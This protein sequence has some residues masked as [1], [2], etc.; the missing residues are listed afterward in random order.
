MATIKEQR[1]NAP[2]CARLGRGRYCAHHRSLYRHY[3]APVVGPDKKLLLVH[4]RYLKKTLGQLVSADDETQGLIRK[5]ASIAFEPRPIHFQDNRGRLRR[6]AYEASVWQV[7]RIRQCHPG[8]ANER[9]AERLWWAFLTVQ[10]VEMTEVFVHQDRHH[11]WTSVVRLL[12][13]DTHRNKPSSRYAD[14]LQ[15]RLNTLLS[16]PTAKWCSKVEL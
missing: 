13:T 9:L 3:G 16:T 1:C 7:E 14:Y 12:I 2:H 8:E 15:E 4:Q 10:F 6:A 5:V 11:F